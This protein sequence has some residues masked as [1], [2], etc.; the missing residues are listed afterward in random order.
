MARMGNPVRALMRL[1]DRL[2]GR[3]LYHRQPVSLGVEIAFTVA[4]I[5]LGILFAALSRDVFFLLIPL[6]PMAGSWYRR[7]R[8]SRRSE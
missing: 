6:I 7:I 5:A 2:L 3:W 1:D 4:A 8:H